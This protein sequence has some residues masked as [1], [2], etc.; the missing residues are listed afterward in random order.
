MYP[1]ESTHEEKQINI[2]VP[3]RSEI[4]ELC[5]KWLSNKGWRLVMDDDYGPVYDHPNS[6]YIYDPAYMEGI[7]VSLNWPE[8]LPRYLP[9]V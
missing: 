2:I 7:Y 3:K 8:L 5:E 1:K 9:S 6:N 4:A